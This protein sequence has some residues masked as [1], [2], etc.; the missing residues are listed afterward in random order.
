MGKNTGALIAGGI[1]VVGSILENIFNTASTN[2]QNRLNRQFSEYMYDKQRADALTDR[3]FQ[4]NYNSPAAQMKRFE[5]AGLN[6]NLIYGQT[7]EGATVRSSTFSQPQQNAPQVDFSGVGKG[8]MAYF[9][10]TLKQAQTNNVDALTKVAVQ[11]A[12]LTAANTI[13]AQ[14]ETTKIKADTMATGAGF[15][16]TIAETLRI[17]QDTRQSAESFPTTLEKNKQEL[18]KLKADTQYTLNQDQRAAAKNAVDLKE[19]MA[20]IARMAIENAKTQDE[21]NKI[22]QEINNL[23]KDGRVKELDLKLKE[24]GIQPGDNMWFRMMGQWM[25]DRMPHAFRGG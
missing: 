14:A 24:M 6:R 5:E 17:M 19:G 22:Q 21:R 15:G 20:R 13:K 16:R 1:P 2:R 3:D 11:T 10:A 8:L 9:D 7:N 23:F 12:A 25:H 4:N 18:A